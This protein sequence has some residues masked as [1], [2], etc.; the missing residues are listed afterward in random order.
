MGAA[1][2][3]MSAD[4]SFKITPN[5]EA[6]VPIRDDLKTMEVVVDESTAL[7]RGLRARHTT[8]IG[9]SL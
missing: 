5:L 6:N 3:T 2:A 1:D 8:M 9:M 4:D 7:H